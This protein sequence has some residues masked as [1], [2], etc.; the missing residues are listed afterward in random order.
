MI[1]WIDEFISRKTLSANSAASYRYDLKAFCES[2]GET[3]TEHRLRL[4]QESLSA[5]KVSAQKRKISAVNQFLYDLYQTGKMERFYKLRV[6]EKLP[7]KQVPRLMLETDSF[8]QETAYPKGQLIALLILEL[9]LTPSD[10][11][12][13]EVAHIDKDLQVVTVR[14]GQSVRV[15]KLPKAVLPY[16][17]WACDQRYLFDKKGQPY[18]RQWFFK[19][20]T[21]YLNEIGRG[22]LTAQKLREQYILREKARGTGLLDLTKQL[23]L[24]TTTTLETYYNGY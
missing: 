13:L 12:R 15:L 14:R 24:S 18:S 16:L 1:D 2:V 7:R 17:D 22:D 21:A 9:G 10:M 5:L 8:Y 23:G 20:L 19:Q 3:V 4:Y 6:S 11:M